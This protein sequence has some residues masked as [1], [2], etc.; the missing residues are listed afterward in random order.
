MDFISADHEKNGDLCAESC[1]RVWD[2]DSKTYLGS[3]FLSNTTCIQLY[4]FKYSYQ[5]LIICAQSYDFKNSCKISVRVSSNSFYSIITICL[6]I[7]IWFQITN[8][9]PLQ[10]IQALSKLFFILI[11]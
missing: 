3:V 5:I 6:R 10:T 9:N 4:G 7:V 1:D 8:N 11:I 2:L